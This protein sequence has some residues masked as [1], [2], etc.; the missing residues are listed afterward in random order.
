M[1]RL[2]GW[3]PRSLARLEDRQDALG[4]VDA[5]SDR[6]EFGHLPTELA[7]KLADTSP[8]D[9]AEVLDAERAGR[10]GRNTP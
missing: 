3:R 9:V 2:C 8:I 7:D 10:L 5:S 1:T 4:D 6:P